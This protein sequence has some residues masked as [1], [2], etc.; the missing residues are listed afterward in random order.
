MA[1]HF[2]H[3]FAASRSKS[4]WEIS[5]SSYLTLCVHAQISKYGGTE[6]GAFVNYR[7]GPGAGRL[8]PTSRQL[9]LLNEKEKYR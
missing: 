9:L 3:N 1:S 7:V 5:H 2:V 6:P 4:R 8:P